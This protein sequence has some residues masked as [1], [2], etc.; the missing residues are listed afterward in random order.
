MKFIE[1]IEFIYFINIMKNDGY[2]SIILD[3][4]AAIL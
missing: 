3:K 4:K 1:F 2:A